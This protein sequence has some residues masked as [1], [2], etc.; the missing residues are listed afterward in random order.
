LGDG[1]ASP[2]A[3]YILVTALRIQVKPK[4]QCGSNTLI[5]AT[6]FAAPFLAVRRL[7]LP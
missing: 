5:R 1:D 4:P 3:V 7:V 2:N 6:R